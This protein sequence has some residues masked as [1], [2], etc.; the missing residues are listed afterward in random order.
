MVVH[1]VSHALNA[2]PLLSSAD[3]S[4]SLTEELRPRIGE[5]DDARHVSVQTW[6]TEPL[7]ARRQGSAG[8]DE[9]L[10]RPASKGVV[11]PSDLKCRADCLDDCSMALQQLSAQ[12]ADEDH[13]STPIDVEHG[14]RIVGQLFTEI[15]NLRRERDCLRS[16]LVDAGFSLRV[17]RIA[18]YAHQPRKS[19]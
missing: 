3:S 11:S 16:A 18:C 17:E 15:E 13:D 1:G 4:H 14:N 8:S 5:S 2:P 12:T 19:N 6:A 9:L 7:L 10:H